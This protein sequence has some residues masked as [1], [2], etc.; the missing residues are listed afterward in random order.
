MNFYTNSGVFLFRLPKRVLVFRDGGQNA[1]KDDYLGVTENL[2]FISEINGHLNFA[3][4][5][6]QWLSFYLISNYQN[7]Y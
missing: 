1:I 7:K 2:N 5:P 4:F 6:R 3:F